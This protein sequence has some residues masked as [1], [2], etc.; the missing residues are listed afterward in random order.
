MDLKKAAEDTKQ[1]MTKAA[2]HT[3]HSFNTLHTGK[4]SPAMVE[5]VTVE[6]HGANMRLREMAAITTPDSRNIRIEPWDKGLLSAVE[7]AI[8]NAN[9]GFNPSIDGQHVR[10]P[11]PDLSKERRQQMVK[12]ATDMAEEGRVAI[13][14]IRQDI[15]TSSKKALKDK[16]ITEDEA[17]RFDKEIQTLTDKAIQDVEQHLKAKEKELLTV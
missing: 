17:K 1:K 2:E 8:R 11:V 16:F 15:L 6:A 14:R 5:N 3:R 13:R 10:C 12:V 7:K 9:L 4:A